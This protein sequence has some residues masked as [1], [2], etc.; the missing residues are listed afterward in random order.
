MD[1]RRI[2]QIFLIAFFALDIFLYLL[3]KE[4]GGDNTEMNATLSVEARMKKDGIGFP[5]LLEKKQKGYYLSAEPTNFQLLEETDGENPFFSGK[6]VSFPTNYTFSVT[7]NKKYTVKENLEGNALGSFLSSTDAVL[8]GKDYT[9]LKKTKEKT[10]TQQSLLL[11]QS[12][13]GLPFMDEA[14]KMTILLKK[15]DKSWEFNHYTQT[16][17]SQIEP[18]RE[19]QELISMR[20]AI[21]T[22]Y[23]NSKI[24][25]KS[26]ISSCE[27]GYVNI[28]S[29]NNKQVFVPA[30]IVKLEIADGTAIEQ[31]NAIT[32]T[33]FSTTGISVGN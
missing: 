3:Y 29:V 15:N 26:K 23:N 19:K 28:L 4:N 31:V 17:L 12:Y 14:S 25:N 13:E 33:I 1:F 20:E 6:T 32:N 5:T 18:L 22:L 27:L 16:H 8:Y 21:T 9:I 11:S 2:I 24:P 7:S 10:G 30:W